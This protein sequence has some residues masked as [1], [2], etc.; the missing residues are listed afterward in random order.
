M[1]KEMTEILEWL[2]K[3]EQFNLPSWESLP[4]LDLYMDQVL[5]YLERTLAPLSVEE[6][7]KLITAFMINN[8][9]KANLIPSPVKKKYSKEHIGFILGICSVKQILSLSD[10]SNLRHRIKTDNISDLYQIFIQNW[11][12]NLHNMANETSNSIN[13]IIERIK[14]IGESSEEDKISESIKDNLNYLALKLAI[15]AEAKKIIADKILYILNENTEEK[16]RKKK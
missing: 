1:N 14:L 2:E 6:H 11:Q 8:Y 15:E 12:D 16:S 5:T 4:D 7:E 13:E 3:L 9:A 10:I